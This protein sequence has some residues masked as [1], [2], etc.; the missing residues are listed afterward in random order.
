MCS[1]VLVDDNKS[2]DDFADLSK[3]LVHSIP[4]DPPLYG[5]ACIAC[6]CLSAAHSLAPTLLCT[7]IT[8]A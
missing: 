5:Y 4:R 2:D 3:V 1:L 6:L 7:W 8:L